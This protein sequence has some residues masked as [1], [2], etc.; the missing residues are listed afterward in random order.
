MRHSSSH[1]VQ[2]DPLFLRPADIPQWRIQERHFIGR[3]SA[4]NVDRPIAD[5]DPLA[6]VR[7]ADAE[8]RFECALL[9]IAPAN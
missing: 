4:P 5:F 6:G 1:P 2:P 9:P 3:E 8:Q 7:V